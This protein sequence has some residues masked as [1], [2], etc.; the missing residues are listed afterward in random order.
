MVNLFE[1]PTAVF[2]EAEIKNPVLLLQPEDTCL[3]VWAEDGVLYNAKLLDWQP[4]HTSADVWFFDYGNVERVELSHMYI[5]Y[6]DVPGYMADE[7]LVDSYVETTPSSSFEPTSAVGVWVSPRKDIFGWEEE[8]HLSEEEDLD[9]LLA[10]DDGE[11]MNIKDG[12]DIKEEWRRARR[13]E[14]LKVQLAVVA[15]LERSLTV[16]GSIDA[17]YLEDI[18]KKKEYEMELKSLEDMKV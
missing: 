18:G 6:S 2:T 13:I 15:N 17:K 3:A 8:E 4:G 16:I 12:V 10:S 1:E 9:L 11:I 14:D 7:G 5:S